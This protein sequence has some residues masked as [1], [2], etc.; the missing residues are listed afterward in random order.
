L[1][2]RRLEPGSGVLAPFKRFHRALGIELTMKCPLTCGHCGYSSGPDRTEAV[3]A[4]LLAE[5]IEADDRIQ[6]LIVSGGEPFAAPAA[7][8]RVLAAARRRDLAVAVNTAAHWATSVEAART[9]LSRFEGITQLDVS[10][11]PWHTPFVPLANVR[12]A[13]QAALDLGIVAVLIV[14]VFDQQGDPFLAELEAALGELVD[15]VPVDLGPVSRVGRAEQIAPPS[16]WPAPTDPRPA[17]ACDWAHAPVVNTDGRVFACCNHA[18]ASTT[19]ALQLGHL[20]RDS[21]A[22]ITAAADHDL[23]LQAI[24]ALGPAWLAKHVDLPATLHAKGDI[25]GLCEQLLADPER[26]AHLRALL[27][28]ERGP[29]AMARLLRFGE[30]SPDVPELTP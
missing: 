20:E 6:L 24:R 2:L 5:R 8:R 22:D 29:I 17:G 14:R 28:D 21:L 4:G 12:N 27:D 23:V 3:D 19:P 13:C 11:D 16:G 7:L 25:C 18:V 1:S 30:V 26:V 15:R 10:A 9:V